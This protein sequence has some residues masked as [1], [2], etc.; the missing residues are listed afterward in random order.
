M[1]DGRVV[2]KLQQADVSPDRLQTPADEA[3]RREYAQLVGNVGS[4]PVR[5]PTINGNAAN[6][7]I[8][9]YIRNSVNRAR[10]RGQ[11]LRRSFPSPTHSRDIRARNEPSGK[12]APNRGRSGSD[13]D[14][15]YA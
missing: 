15:G 10:N 1:D 7:C 2:D 13:P 9:P 11:S 12:D 6:W 8:V 14:G 5:R 4:E 3:E